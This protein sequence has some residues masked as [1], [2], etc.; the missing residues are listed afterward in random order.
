MKTAMLKEQGTPLRVIIAD[1]EPLVRKSVRRFLRPYDV[2]VVCECADGRS[3][4]QAIWEMNPGLVFLDL[5]MPELD[6]RQVIAEV[7]ER[8]PPTIILTAHND[9]AVEAYDANVIDYVLKPFGQERFERAM[10]RAVTR[11]QSIEP[12][13]QTVQRALEQKL[14]Q[15]VGQLRQPKPWQDRIAMPIGDGRLSFLEAKDIDW[16]EAQGNNLKVHCGQRC[17]EVRETL[18]GFHRRL[19]PGVF[20][21]IHRSTVV[22]VNQIR[23]VQTWFKGH[24][25]VVLR[26]GKEL[27]MSR[28]Q[29]AGLDQLLRK[30]MV[31]S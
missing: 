28:H 24:H 23:E 17:Y 25:L 20:L 19:D 7:Q 30:D 12:G 14:E 5:Q 9:Y 13:T 18:S 15:L 22:N 16:V 31:A 1:D 10:V 8:M 27:R 6:G 3:C 4:V 2:E 29:N 26:C 21:R 11:I